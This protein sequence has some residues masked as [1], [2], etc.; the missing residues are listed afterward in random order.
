M[1]FKKEKEYNYFDYFIKNVGFACE[2]ADY[3]AESLGNYDSTLF[4][5]R[6]AH[7]HEIENR[8]DDEKH[9]MMSRLFHEFLPPIDREDIVELAHYLD[10]VVDTIDDVML[11]VD[12]YCLTEI[13]PEVL[14]F[15]KLICRCTQEL[16]VLVTKFK[17]FKHA[18]DIREAIVTVNAIE[19]EGDKLHSD[20]IRAMYQD[21]TVD[22][23][24]VIAWSAIYDDLEMCLD[25]C[26]HATDVIETVL[27]KNT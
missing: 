9:E 13:R 24:R 14:E 7:M 25:A 20:C 15:T 3:L 17:N 5:T 12:M 27:M 19:S 4:R 2:A 16:S 1:L 23:K 8:A 22:A 11:R 21:D 6:V 18:K 26:E 10:D